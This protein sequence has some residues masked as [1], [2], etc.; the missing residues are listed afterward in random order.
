MCR[1][2]LAFAAPVRHTLPVL[3]QR[4]HF[5]GVVLRPLTRLPPSVFRQKRGRMFTNFFTT[6][7]D[8]SGGQISII[9]EAGHIPIS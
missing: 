1:L 3:R 7:V 2:F 9:L 5:A 8:H 4:A 6:N